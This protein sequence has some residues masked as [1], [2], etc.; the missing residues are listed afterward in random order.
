MQF[1]KALALATV[2]GFTSFAAPAGAQDTTGGVDQTFVT[3]FVHGNNHEIEQAQ[4]ELTTATDPGIILFANTMIKDHTAA[5]GQ[6]AAAAQ[7]L[8]LTYPQSHI[9]TGHTKVPNSPGASAAPM[10]PRSYMELQVQE[11]QAV[12]GLL[13]GEADNGSSA[14]LKTIAAQILPVAKAHLAMAQQ[15]LASGTVSPEVLPTPGS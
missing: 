7:S 4:A 12:I 1:V 10:T 11:H 3:Q 6:V 8:G 5:N 9:T 13:Q 2:A 14:Q 15:F